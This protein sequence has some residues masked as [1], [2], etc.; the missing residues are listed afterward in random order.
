M[1]YLMEYPT[2]MCYLMEYPTSWP[3]LTSSSSATLWRQNC[4][5]EY[6]GLLIG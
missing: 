4:S 6:M 1:C 3:R 5:E 2:L